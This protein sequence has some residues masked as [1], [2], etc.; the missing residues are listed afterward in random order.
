MRTYDLRKNSLA[1]Y[2]I[3]RKSVRMIHV[4]RYS[5]AHILLTHLYF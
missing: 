1:R 5:T 3:V 4:T 2:F